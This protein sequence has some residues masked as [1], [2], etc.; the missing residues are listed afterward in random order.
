MPFLRVRISN[1]QVVAGDP[2]YV[3]LAVLVQIGHDQPNAAEVKVEVVLDQ[4]FAELAVAEVLERPKLFVVLRDQG[5]DIRFAV[6]IEI[7]DWHVDG[8][9][10]RQQEMVPK[11][12][13]AAILQPPYATIVVAKLG[14]REVNRAVA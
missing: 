8:A 5:Q 1:L 13:V 3:R 12:A 9:R 14:D 6:T 11:T 7:G 10:R 4:P 2:E